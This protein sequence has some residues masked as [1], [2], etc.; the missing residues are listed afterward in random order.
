MSSGCSKTGSLYVRSKNLPFSGE[1]MK[2]VCSACSVCAEIKPQ[3]HHLNPGTLI[4]STQPFE[5]LSIDFKGTLPSM[6]SKYL[7]AFDEFSRFPFCY[8]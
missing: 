8:P 2:R 6:F 4:K 7:F 3:F 5:P 1:N